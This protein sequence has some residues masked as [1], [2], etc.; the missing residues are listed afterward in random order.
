MLQA[1]FESTSLACSSSESW[2]HLSKVGWK[3]DDL[4]VPYGLAVAKAAR[5]KQRNRNGRTMWSNSQ[6][7][8]GMNDTLLSFVG[9]SHLLRYLPECQEWTYLQKDKL[10]G[11]IFRPSWLPTNIWPL[12]QNVQLPKLRTMSNASL[13]FPQEAIPNGLKIRT[14]K[15]DVFILNKWQW[16]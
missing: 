3:E 5:P 2:S 1:Y 13:H 8:G 4:L 9:F 16:L 11:K 15:A 12:D 14:K 10:R 6:L 7:S